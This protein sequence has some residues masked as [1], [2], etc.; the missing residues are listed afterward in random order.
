MRI[1]VLADEKGVSV[2]NC[3]GWSR[4]EP[5]WTLPKAW[6]V[7]KTIYPQI[8]VLIAKSAF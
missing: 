1:S 6:A 2:S 8:S 5:Y 4:P 3:R 7:Q